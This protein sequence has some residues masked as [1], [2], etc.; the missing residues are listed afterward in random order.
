MCVLS[1]YRIRYSTDIPAAFAV[2]QYVREDVLKFHVALDVD[3]A[4][5]E[6]LPSHSCNDCTDGR[7]CEHNPEV[8]PCGGVEYGGAERAGRIYRAVVNRNTDDVHKAKGE[9]DCDAAEFGEGCV[10]IGGTEHDKHEEEREQNLHEQS[11]A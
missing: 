10:C 7:A 5:R 1:S 4:G 2:A 6:S 9:A 3:S 11:H 8:T